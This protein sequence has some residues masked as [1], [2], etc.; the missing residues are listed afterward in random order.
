M[1]AATSLQQDPDMMH[2]ATRHDPAL[3]DSKGNTVLMI[4]CASHQRI[5]RLRQQRAS[6][7][8]TAVTLQAILAV[9]GHSPMFC[10]NAGQCVGDIILNICAKPN[11]KLQPE[12]EEAMLPYLTYARLPHG[13]VKALAPTVI[14]ESLSSL[15]SF[16]AEG[17]DK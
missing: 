14:E 16:D 10:N 17:E 12:I 13:P 11:R 15:T 4:Y 5:H 2:P 8:A 1:W 9:W 3:R 7:R 6:A